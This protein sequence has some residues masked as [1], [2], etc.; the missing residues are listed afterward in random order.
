MHFNPSQLRKLKKG[1]TVQLTATQMAS[2]AGQ[3]VE[4]HMLKKHGTEM[5]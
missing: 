3:V 2:K 5:R 4:L 1:Q